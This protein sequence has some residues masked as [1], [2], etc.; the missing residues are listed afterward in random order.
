[1]GYIYKC[2]YTYLETYLVYTH[3]SIYL[4]IYLYIYIYIIH[5]L[6]IYISTLWVLLSYPTPAA[7]THLWH[8]S[9]SSS[10]RVASVLGGLQSPSHPEPEDKKPSMV[11]NLVPV[12]G[13]IG[14]I[15]HPPIGRKNTTYI[16]LIY[17]LLMHG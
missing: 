14:G 4:F 13:G 3:I 9:M 17:C 11:G 2:S 1:M 8:V 5:V 16:P 7:F 6:Y 15:V 10:R 12:K